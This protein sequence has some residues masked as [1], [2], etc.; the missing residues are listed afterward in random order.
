MPPEHFVSAIIW[1]SYC[2][3]WCYEL[4]YAWKSSKKL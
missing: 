1:D 3:F 4:Q 2:V